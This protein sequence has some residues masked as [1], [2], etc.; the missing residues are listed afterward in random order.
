MKPNVSRETLE[1]LWSDPANWRYGLIYHCKED[2]RVWVPKRQKWRGWTLNLA[3]PHAIPHLIL[4]M[5]F[6][7]L[8]M[9]LLAILGFAGTW[10]WWGTLG[11]ILAIVCLACWYWASPDRYSK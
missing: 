6:V 7:A 2:P 3:H 9:Y 1:R 5:L 4:V 11:S 8:P 10:V